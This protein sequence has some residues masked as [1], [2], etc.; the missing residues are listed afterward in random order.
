MSQSTYISINALPP[1]LAECWGIPGDAVVSYIRFYL[2]GAEGIE[3]VAVLVNSQHYWC[4]R[5]KT[6]QQ[7]TLLSV[8]WREWTMTE[9]RMDDLS[10]FGNDL[11]K[12]V[13][14]NIT[15]TRN[16]FFRPVSGATRHTW[17]SIILSSASGLVF[18]VGLS[19][20]IVVIINAVLSLFP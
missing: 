20:I 1:D 2:L 15:A 12:S 6:D 17:K 5:F 14:L 18:C 7:V 16:R 13:L 9:V 10:I 4:C 11:P 19:V 8:D 3:L